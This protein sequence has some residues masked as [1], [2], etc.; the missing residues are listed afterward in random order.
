[1]VDLGEGLGGSSIIGENTQCLKGQQV[2]DIP[3]LRPNWPEKY[4]D[5]PLCCSR[6]LKQHKAVQGFQ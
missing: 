2:F 4:L 1:M 6:A 3:S 5:Q